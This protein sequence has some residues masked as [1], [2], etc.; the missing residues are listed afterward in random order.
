MSV[1]TICFGKPF[2]K[3]MHWKS[4]FGNRLPMHSAVS[5]L[6]IF[7]LFFSILT[8]I[9]IKNIG[10]FV[11]F[12]LSTESIKFIPHALICKSVKQINEYTYIWAVLSFKLR[13]STRALGASWDLLEP[14]CP[15]WRS[16]LRVLQLPWRLLFPSSSTSSLALVSAL[17]IS[18]YFLSF[19]CYDRS[20][21]LGIIWP[22]SSACP[23]LLCPVG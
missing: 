15:A 20:L 5:L 18:R 2:W 9:L 6:N 23:P 10:F 11:L 13:S 21:S 22:P 4:S 7:F 17:D 3:I 12:F 16:L 19:L 1:T 14:L 8:T